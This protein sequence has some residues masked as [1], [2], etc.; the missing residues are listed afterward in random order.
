M[1]QVVKQNKRK[2]QILMAMG[3]VGAASVAT[4]TQTAHADAQT[5]TAEGFDLTKQATTSPFPVMFD[6]PSGVNA[7]ALAGAVRTLGTDSNLY[8]SALKAVPELGQ[9]NINSLLNDALSDNA[10]TA[11]TARGTILKLINWYNSLGGFQIKTQDGKAYTVD[12]LDE[13]INTIAVGFANPE[14]NKAVSDKIQKDFGNIKT[15]GDVM[16]ALDAHKAGLSTAYKQ[17]FDAYAAKVN[18]KG[19]DL[20][21]LTEY[22][23]LKPLLNAYEGLYANGAAALRGE[24]LAQSGTKEAAVAFFES[25]VITGQIDNKSNGDTDQNQPKNVKTRW[26]DTEGKPLAPEE[27][28]KDFKGEKTFDGYR[29]RESRTENGIRTYVYE[30]IQKPVEP[31]KGPDKTIWVDKEGKTLKAEQE[32]QHPDKE[33]DDIPGYRLVQTKTEKGTDGS[34]KVT[35]IYEKVR[36]P[37]TYWFDSEG[38]ELKP[39]AKEQSLPDNDGVSDVPGYRLIRAYTVTKADLAGDLKGSKFQEGDIINI[40]EKDAEKPVEKPKRT[41]WVDEQGNKLKDPQDGEHPDKEGDD[42]P[43]YTLVRID[44][45]KDGNVTNVYKKTPEKPVEK[46]KRTTWVDEQGNKLKDPQDG[47]H[48]DKEGDDVPGYTLVRIDKDKDGNV[49]NVYKK[50]EKPVEEVQTKWVDEQ[51]NQLKEPQKGAHPDVEGD[52]V[53]GYKILRTI[54]DEKGNI[55]NVYEKVKTPEKSKNTTWVDEQGNQLKEP[56]EGEHPD[57]EGDD[58]PGYQLVKVDHDKDGNVINIYKKVAKKVTTHWVDKD[59]NR[60]AQ[61]VTGEEFDKQKDFPGYHLADVRTSKDG[62]EKFYIYEK[63]EAPKAKELPKTGD[64]SGLA[65]IVGTALVGLGGLGFRRKKGKKAE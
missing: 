36:K 52:D 41:T 40:Y 38:K 60:L 29:I 46:P 23:A 44:K 18:A 64:V 57:N 58:I 30:K 9:A 2:K 39:V 14:A 25:A 7:A 62:T 28:G 56:Q 6:R 12:N 10:A 53:P 47:E 61:D 43:G 42:V 1:T 32:G 54:K 20:A 21:K 26:V 48:P 19:A 50:A 11:K 31:K 45:D 4:L 27:T 24:L 3:I 55:T 65:G 35:N 34:V 22:E 59:G 51:G 17:A 8:A 5:Q 13:P 16:K 49:T 33:G 63:D 15:T 37:D